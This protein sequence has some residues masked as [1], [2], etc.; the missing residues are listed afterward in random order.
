MFCKHCG[1]QLSDG[2]NFCSG[3]GQA[4]NETQNPNTVSS[5]L[6]T[7]IATQQSYQTYPVVYQRKSNK[8]LFIIIGCIV[9]VIAIIAG[10]FMAIDAAEEKRL[11]EERAEERR[12]ARMGPKEESNLRSCYSAACAA[13]T[14]L[15]V[16]GTFNKNELMDLTIE[17]IGGESKVPDG[18]D[19]EF[20]NTGIKS[21]SI[22]CALGG[23]LY[24]DGGSFTGGGAE[25]EHY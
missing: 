22:D 3:C 2:V 25:H 12:I 10:I 18:F 15:A 9:A 14:Q 1:K 17:L 24:Y 7:S 6:S 16:E 20:D 13:Y 5:P 23:T 21:V 19:V 8:K 11:K 4:V